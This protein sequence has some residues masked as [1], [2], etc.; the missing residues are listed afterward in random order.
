MDVFN[1]NLQAN[2]PN[3]QLKSVALQSF[4]LLFGCLMLMASADAQDI[5]VWDGSE[6]N[7]WRNDRNWDFGGTPGPNQEAV[8]TQGIGRNNVDLSNSSGNDADRSVLRIRFRTNGNNTTIDD[9]FGPNLDLDA[10][11]FL[12]RGRLIIEDNTTFSAQ[13]I[14]W[15][16]TRTTANE[17]TVVATIHLTA[18]DVRFSAEPEFSYSGNPGST[19]DVEALNLYGGLSGTSNII[20]ASTS[21]SFRSRLILHEQNNF[22]GTISI[23]SSGDLFLRHDMALQNASVDVLAD[24]VFGFSGVDPVLDELVNNSQITVAGRTLTFGT[25]EARS[26]NGTFVGS[27]RIR[28][29]GDHAWTSNADENAYI[30]RID[31]AG[32]APFIAGRAA[33][34]TNARIDI[35]TNNGFAFT[36]DEAR[37]GGLSGTGD[38]TLGVNKVLRLDS[39][40]FDLTYSGDLLGPGQLIQQNNRDWTF[41]GI[42]EGS[43]RVQSGT[44][45]GSGTMADVWINPNARISPGASGAAGDIGSQRFINQ[46]VVNGTMDVDIDAQELD[47]FLVDGQLV[48]DGASLNV[49]IATFQPEPAFI[50]ASYDQRIGEFASVTGLPPTVDL[51]YDW[52]DGTGNTNNIALV[53]NVAPEANDDAYSTLEDIPLMGQNVLSNDLDG[54]LDTLMVITAGTFPADGIGGTVVLEPNGDFTYTPPADAFGTASFTYEAEDNNGATDTA[55]VTITVTPVN[56]APSFSLLGGV[57]AFEDAPFT[58][59]LVVQSSTAGPVNEQDQF[60]F[61]LSSN[62]NPDLFQIQ[63]TVLAST[64]E[65]SFTPAPDAFGSAEIE[66]ILLDDGGDANGGANTSPPQTFTIS[67]SAVNDAP[68]FTAVDPPAIDENAGP[69]TVSAWAAFDPGPENE[70]DQLVLEY[71]IESISNPGLF[72]VAPVVD[73]A[74]NLTYTPADDVFGSAT[75]EVRVRD[76]GGLVNGGVDTSAVQSFTITINEVNAAPTFT[77]GDP[78][79]V[80]ED[81]GAQTVNSWA[82]FDPG[83]PDENGQSVLAY[84]VSNVSNEDLFAVMPTVDINGNLSYTPADDAFGM[85][86]FDVTVQDD[87]GTANGGVDMSSAQTFTITINAVNDAPSFVATDPPPVNEDEDPVRITG[88]AVFD[89]GAAN[90]DSQSAFVY[91]ITNISNPLLFDEPPSVDANGNLTY[92]VAGG[93]SGTSMFDIVVQ[94]NGGTVNGGTVNGG[95]DTSASQTFTITILSVNDAPTFTAVDP[96]LLFEDEESVTL[97]NWA[98]FDSGAVDEGSQS[99]LAYRVS[100]IG[101]SDLFSTPP[102]VS[103]DGALSFTLAPDA[104]GT[105]TFNVSV[106]DDGGTANGGDDTS[107]PQTFT[108]TVLPVNDPPTFNHPVFLGLNANEDGNFLWAQNIRPGPDDESGQMVMFDVT[109]VSNPAIFDQQPIIDSDGRL[110]FTLDVQDLGEEMSDVTVVAVDDGGVDNGGVPTSDPVT[111]NIGVF[112]AAD[113]SIEKTS[114]SFFVDPGGTITYTIVVTNNGP[115]VVFDAVVTDNP[116]PRLGNLSW[117]CTTE[118][119][120]ICGSPSGTGPIDELVSFLSN[121]SVTYTLTAT[122]QDTSNEPITNTASVAPP[123]DVFDFE[124]ANNSDSDTDIVGLFADGME[125]EEP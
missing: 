81:A 62:D 111:F 12:N 4:A 46:L 11:W 16:N 114:D 100:N 106:Q 87:G 116:L 72:A 71:L 94:D 73:T 101:N 95:Q 63:P 55:M 8:M 76:D 59:S 75:F 118:G 119:D 26:N 123:E 43:I 90:E 102:A 49:R 20:L 80:D 113:L 29:V 51:R 69:Q 37:I 61:F 70:S 105:T 78:P 65:V 77:A 3:I 89:P 10:N 35:K 74:G 38:L 15:V 60:L 88:W 68:T 66:L 41:D 115:S 121:S 91:N 32:T 85:S 50:F 86:T 83:S 108:I 44:L 36:P 30:G 27:G 18:P 125:S 21:P 19:N 25:R 107:D 124:P 48:L 13:R 112:P 117:T 42:S 104:N 109:N 92:E 28:F 14:S 6:N 33:T 17:I 1:S 45:S 31:A 103:I 99:V 96:P 56:D 58:Q 47:Q 54:D 5:R 53:L 34:W 2:Q 120:A 23:A 84:T 57:I 97:N 40:R 9:Y 22:S 93:V 79:P 122:L 64:G 24:G 82:V 52:D 98:N 110:T 39:D 67:I 7:N